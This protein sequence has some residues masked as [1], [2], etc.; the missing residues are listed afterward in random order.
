MENGRLVLVHLDFLIGDVLG[1]CRTDR[2]WLELMLKDLLVDG[3]V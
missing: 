1:D 3:E 2:A